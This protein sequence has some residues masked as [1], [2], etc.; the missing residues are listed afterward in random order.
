LNHGIKKYPYGWSKNAP[1]G[2]VGIACATEYK[3][4]QSWLVAEAIRMLLVSG[5]DRALGQNMQ[6]QVDTEGD[7]EEMLLSRMPR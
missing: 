2:V 5:L 7:I 1:H 3:A 6:L 4:S